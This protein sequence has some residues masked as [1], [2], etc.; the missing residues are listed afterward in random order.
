MLLLLLLLLLVAILFD[1][2]ERRHFIPRKMGDL[3]VV[4]LDGKEELESKKE[5]T[6]DV[7]ST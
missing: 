2:N 1:W 6:A 7:V 4:V 3:L 5:S